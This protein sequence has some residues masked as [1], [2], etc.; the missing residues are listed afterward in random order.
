VALWGCTYDNCS[1]KC[2]FC[3]GD[4]SV[5]ETRDSP[6]GLRRRRLCS[7]C[8]R[9]FTTY[10]Q[11]SSPGLKVA[12]RDG[13]AEPFDATKLRTALE[14]ITAHRAEVKPDDLRRVVS[15][16][17]AALV[18]SGARAVSWSE[19]VRLVLER[20]TDIDVVSAQ[21]MRA[22][23]LDDEGRMRLEDDADSD[24]RELP[25]LPLTGVE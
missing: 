10:E 24:D 4:S 22:N 7:S 15:S 11:A 16:V 2:P 9:R 23:Y 5:T 1:V 3:G 13:T 25:Q 12:K 19:I 20:L 18:D 6:E 21:R 17:E 14:R 8:K